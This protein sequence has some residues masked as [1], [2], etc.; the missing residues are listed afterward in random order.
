LSNGY[1]RSRLGGG[2][3]LKAVTRAKRAAAGHRLGV[4]YCEVKRRNRE[5]Y[6][7]DL[8]ARMEAGTLRRQRGAG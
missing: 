3:V 5:A 6:L 2:N 4:A 8:F 7:R 1:Q